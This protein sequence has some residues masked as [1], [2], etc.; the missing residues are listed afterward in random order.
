MAK[1][2]D[3]VK[4]KFITD[5][6]EF[7]KGIN[8]INSDIATLNS[9]LRLNATQLK[10]NANDTALLK[11]RQK[12][13]SDKLQESTQKVELTTQKLE[14]A[15]EIYGADS[16]AVQTYE[17][18]LNDAKNQEESIRNAIDQCNESIRQN[19]EALRREAEA[20]KESQSATGQLTSEIEKQ[21]TEL[22]GLKKQYVEAVLEEGEASDKAQELAKEIKDLNQE[23][24]ENKGQLSNAQ[25][26]ADGLTEELEE[27]GNAAQSAA[28]GGFTV[29]K[30]VLADLASNAIQMA[31]STLKDFAGS[32]IETGSGFEASMSQVAAVSGAAGDDFL[33]LRDKAQEMGATTKFTA[34]E[35]AEA[36][37]YM[38]MAGWKTNDMLEGI[39]GIM[40]LA[41]AS[42]EDLATT[43]DIVTDALTA[44]GMSAEESGHFADV[45]AAASANAN[46][47]V[48]MLGESFKYVAPVA[49]SLGYSAEDTSIALGLMANAGIKASQ[50]GTAL[51]TILTNLAKPTDDVS[52]AMGKMGISLDDGEGNMLS[53]R[54]LMGDL[55]EAFGN[56][57]VSVEEYAN[58]MELLDDSLASGQMTQKQYNAAVEELEE[59]TFGAEG[60]LK[61]QAAATIAG[62]TGM[63]GLLAIVN[64]SDEDFNKLAEAID[65]ATDAETG[66]SAAAEM[67]EEMQDNLQ[68]D[69]T[70]M[71]S[72]L[73]GVRQHIYDDLNEPMRE[74][75]Q[76][77]TDE[78]IPAAQEFYDDL[79][80]GAAWL[81]EH[82]TAVEGV[83][84]VI[85]ALAAGIT[86]YNIVTGV[87]TAMEAANAT[88]VWGLVTA[89]L[90]LNT[91]FLASP[92]TWVVAGV[93][94]L[95]AG[96]VLLWNKSEAFRDFWKGLW[97]GLK[98]IV[99]GVKDK[100]EE[101]IGK[102]GEK[103]EALKNGGKNALNGLKTI[104]ANELKGTVDTFK[105]HGGGIEGAAAVAMRLMT[106]QFR[107]GYE[108]LNK[109]TGGK[110]DEL[111]GKATEKFNAVKDIA[112]EKL[113]ALEGLARK[114]LDR[115]KNTFESNGGGIK[116]VAAVYMSGIHD[117]FTA[118][119]N[120]L[121]KLTGGKLDGLKK[122]AEEKLEGAKEKFS[123]AIEKIKGFFDFRIEW[124][125]ISVPSITV[126]WQSGGNL[127]KAAKLLGFPGLPKFGIKWNA[128]GAILTRPMIFGYAGGKLQGAGEAGPEAVLPIEKL[129]D[130]IGNK[131]AEFVELIPQIDYDKLGKAVGA[132][133]REQD[134]KIILDNRETG[135]VFRRLLQ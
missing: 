124:P 58:R 106:T 112:G 19:E 35:S 116:G 31:G 20:E 38:A 85:G 50:G 103:F 48:S 51:R 78:V 99:S 10:G 49:G 39:S 43:S 88:S 111:K 93:V 26:A 89:Q 34:T 62:K 56:T 131:M 76:K 104:A 74:L 120:A 1:A 86:A 2:K 105:E 72:A 9:A 21:E 3:E 61:A 66:Y 84:I 68:G 67:A 23:L 130:Y 128:E 122:T 96:F 60:A 73:D 127:A 90:A 28:D 55:R 32:I 53:L 47:N 135:R 52:D 42:G 4:I 15:K 27:T 54:E 12:L 13:L 95:V 17:K 7:N 77:V 102:V 119:Y 134:I 65:G 117:E 6:N 121:N 5:T 64:A 57:K 91:A 115:V 40:N 33:A 37:N 94:A 110:L 46:T 69:I 118:G 133:V 82:K 16:E 79:R 126:D 129:E 113:G 14:K 98:G 29:F 41:A 45:I 70:I 132:A 80:T 87:K 114:G 22:E 44:F 83:A 92:V 108:G 18:E 59:D 125:H 24:Q 101:G 8:K 81:N 100:I 63:S 30:G 71:Q 97:D 75:V 123:S 36:M 25:S 109:L 107:L 11:E